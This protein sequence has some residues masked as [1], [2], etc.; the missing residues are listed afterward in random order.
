M[1]DTLPITQNNQKMLILRF[2]FDTS[3]GQRAQNVLLNM[4]DKNKQVPKK[5]VIKKQ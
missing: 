3:K 4:G 1:Y 2:Y 5:E